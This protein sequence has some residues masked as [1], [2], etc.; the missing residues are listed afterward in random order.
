MAKGWARAKTSEATLLAASTGK[1]ARISNTN[2]TMTPGAAPRK[3][4][5]AP[6]AAACHHRPRTAT[7]DPSS[8]VFPRI[9]PRTAA[10]APNIQRTERLAAQG[11]PMIEI[12]SPSTMSQPRASVQTRS[13][14]LAEGATDTRRSSVHDISHCLHHRRGHEDEKH[15]SRQERDHTEHALDF[16]AVL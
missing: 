6:F 1:W 2:P 5:T 4:S 11:R 10:C 7:A 15:P 13:G 8:A 12:V 3:A 16:R 9:P 14:I